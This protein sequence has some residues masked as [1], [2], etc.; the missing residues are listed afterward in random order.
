MRVPA[1]I[2]GVREALPEELRA[3]FATEIDDTPAA[4]LPFT[5]VRWSMNIPSGHDDA[6]EALL[7][8]V[9]SGDF[10][11]VTFADDLGDDEYRS[12]G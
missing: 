6:E 5:L 1:T 9:R 3:R 2:R 7:E 12:A 8:R 10:T 11:E 4:Q